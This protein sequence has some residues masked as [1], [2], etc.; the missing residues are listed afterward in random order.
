[1]GKKRITPGW[2]RKIGVPGV[3]IAG[4]VFGSAYGWDKLKT[5][6]PNY[7][8]NTIV[9][10]YTG[11]VRTVIDGDTIRLYNDFDYRLIGINAPDRGEDK[12]EE[13]TKRLSDLV[14]RKRIWLEYDRYDDDKNGRVLAWVWVGCE[15]VPKFLP[16]DYMHLTFNRSREGLKDNPE[17]CKKGKL[18]QEEMVKSGL[19]KVEVYKDR[20]ELK[21]EERIRSF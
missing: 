17:G 8:K 1:M 3:L 20:G 10:A 2:L 21:Y 19:A 9:F 7:H 14:L 4:L 13:A 5:L 6:G 12:Y 18:V 15:T 11:V 16:A